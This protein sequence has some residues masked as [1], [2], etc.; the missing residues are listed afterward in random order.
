M[1]NFTGKTVLVTGAAGGLGR[2]VALAFAAAG[3]NVAVADLDGAGLDG[4]ASQAREL[5]AEVHAAR[6]DIST[7]QACVDLVAG[8]VNH[9]GGLDV[10]CNVAGVLGPGHAEQLSEALWNKIIAVNLSAP[11]WLIQASL[12]QLLARHGNVVNIASSGAYVGEAYLAPYTAT[13]AGLVQMTRSLAMEFMKKP[14][15]FNCVAPGPMATNMMDGQGFPA[16]V[17]MELVQRYMAVRPAADP[18][19][20]A[21]LVLY[22]ASDRAANIHGACLLSDG[23]HSAG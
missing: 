6:G 13:K 4:T 3:A 7:R 16:D 8:I 15:R 22:L 10:L 20:V 11:F 17:D 18:A 12:P 5:G 9:F 19:Q 2:A 1:E 23:G 14:V 21:D